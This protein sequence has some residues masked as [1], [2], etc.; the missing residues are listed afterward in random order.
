MPKNPRLLDPFRFGNKIKCRTPP[1]SQ[2]RFQRVKAFGFRQEVGCGQG[3]RPDR[4]L[5]SPQRMN[6]VRAAFLWHDNRHMPRIQYRQIG[7]EPRQSPVAV[8]KRMN[9]NK[10]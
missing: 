10:G 6:V 4:P 1:A 9:P 5:I 8:E 7:Q 3:D 2:Q